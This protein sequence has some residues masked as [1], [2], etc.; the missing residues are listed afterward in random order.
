LEHRREYRVPG[1]DD[2]EISTQVLIKEAIDLGIKVEILDRKEQFIRL[3]RNDQKEI[4]KE[5]TKTRLDSYLTFLAMEN[6][7]ISKI[8]MIEEGVPTPRGFTLEEVEGAYLKSQMLSTDLIVIKPKTTN[9]G[10]GVQILPKTS[11]QE[12]IEK[13]MIEALVHSSSF[14]IE[15]FYEGNEY[16]FL[17]IRDRV[18]GVCERIPANVEGDG[19]KTILELVADKNQDPWRGVGHISPL[20]KIQTSSVETEVLSSQGYEWQTIPQEGKRVF[21]RK[22]SNISTGGD[23]VDRTD[24][25]DESYKELARKAAKVARATICGVDI[26]SKDFSILSR[27][28]KHTVLEINF[29]PV[30][31]IHEYPAIGKP[32]RVALEVLKALGFG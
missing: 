23:S 3:S 11:K 28:A 5:A 31:Y 9:F 24:E 4:I 18:V 6:K 1:F 2:L 21:L 19:T 30:L 13:A 8:L 14:L 27:L 15:E 10:I 26:I 20:E 22:N 7:S 25:V 32:R 12:Q 29:N 16:R 17:V